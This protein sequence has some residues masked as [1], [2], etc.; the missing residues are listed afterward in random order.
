MLD[1]KDIRVD[2]YRPGYGPVTVTLTYIPLGKYAK[3][4]HWMECRAK[5]IAMEEL[6]G[7]VREAQES[8][9]LSLHELGELAADTAGGTSALSD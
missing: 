1:P 8:E 5:E 2:T 4:T 7:K 6:I 3:Y 9:R